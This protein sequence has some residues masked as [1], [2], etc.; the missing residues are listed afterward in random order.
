MEVLNKYKI[1]PGETGVYIGRPSPLG[2][3]FQIGEHG[4]RGEV[5]ALFKDY[6][7]SKLA[8]RDP[9]IEM[10]FRKLTPND[11]LICYC[12][13]APCHGHVI[14]ECFDKIWEELDYEAG[15]KH[16]LKHHGKLIDPSL[17]GITHI[18]IYS[19]ASTK[20]G[21]ALSNFAPLGFELPDDGRFE[22]VEGYWYWLGTGCK[23]DKLRTLSGYEA[24]KYGRRFE[25]VVVDGFEEKIKRALKC[26]LDSH[27]GLKKA[28][29]DSTLPFKHYYYYGEPSNAK[30][31]NV[32]NSDW[33]V[34]YIHELREAFKADARS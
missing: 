28:F 6:F 33:I 22:S 34:D 7:L 1:Q 30:V 27:P 14:K 31:V 32:E 2:N 4:D 12:A 26:K 5:V 11:N 10:A 17:D 8:A 15:L 3:P 18:N 16:L 20:L 23:Y 19:K 9:E 21:R 24:K 25:R 29:T 13:P